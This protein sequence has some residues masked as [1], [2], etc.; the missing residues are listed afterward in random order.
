MMAMM[1]GLL[2]LGLAQEHRLGTFWQL[3]SWAPK[4]SQTAKSWWMRAGCKLPGQPHLPRR[5][6]GLGR[7]RLSPSR[8]QIVMVMLIMIMMTESTHSHCGHEGADL[9][10]HLID[11]RE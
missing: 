10:L 8:S 5:V 7:G 9:G 2:K 1:L 11:S 6:K 3:G 4:L